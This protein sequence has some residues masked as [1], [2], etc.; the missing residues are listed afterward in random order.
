MEQIRPGSNP[1]LETKI[2]A[3]ERAP[4]Q[5]RYAQILKILKEEKHPMSAKELAVE[6]YKRGYT[7]SQ[8]RN[9]SAPRITELLISG[10][11]EVAGKEKCKYTGRNVCVFKIRKN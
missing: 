11:L 8:D 9:Y 2:E 7:P 10:Q 5:V 3:N 1:T 6:L 4:K